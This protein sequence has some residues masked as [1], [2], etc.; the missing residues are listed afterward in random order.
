MVPEHDVMTHAG[1]VVTPDEL[2]H[3]AGCDVPRADAASS[4]HLL[5]TSASAERRGRFNQMR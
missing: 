3:G 4:T 5:T 2:D 1:K